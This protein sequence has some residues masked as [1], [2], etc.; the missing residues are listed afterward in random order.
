M[1]VYA[2][3][4]GSWFPVEENQTGSQDLLRFKMG[5]G[6]YLLSVADKGPKVLLQRI[7]VKPD[8]EIQCRFDFTANKCRITE[9]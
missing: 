1:A 5:A 9:N 2:F 4:S 8:K 7:T 6:E 3:G